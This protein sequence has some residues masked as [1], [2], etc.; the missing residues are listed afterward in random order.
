MW[1]ILVIFVYFR[2]FY[3]SVGKCIHSVACARNNGVE[4]KTRDGVKTATERFSYFK[5]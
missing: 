1:Q 4:R 5:L 2:L 3:A